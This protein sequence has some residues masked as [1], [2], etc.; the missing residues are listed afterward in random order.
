M[1]VSSIKG[2]EMGATG[3][4]AIGDALL[5]NGSSKLAYISCDSFKVN[6]NDTML[7]FAQQKL[8]AADARLLSGVLKANFKV[9][10]LK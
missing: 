2:N 6:E 1:C 3:H 4:S 5:Q 9:V 8:G 10:S 7:D